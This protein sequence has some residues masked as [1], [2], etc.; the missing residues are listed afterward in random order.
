VLAAR[1]PLLMA[2]VTARLEQ[3]CPKVRIVVPVQPPVVGAALLGIAALA[4][5]PGW[6][7]PLQEEAIRNAVA[8]AMSRFD[9]QA[10]PDPPK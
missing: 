4:G 6:Q 9:V 7:Q 2:D 8:A 3:V 10:T 1:N 5:T